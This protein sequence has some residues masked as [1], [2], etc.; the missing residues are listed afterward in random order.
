MDPRLF[1]FTS[2]TAEAGHQP[3]GDAWLDQEPIHH[4]NEVVASLPTKLLHHP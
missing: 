2:L 3:E 1:D 4:Q